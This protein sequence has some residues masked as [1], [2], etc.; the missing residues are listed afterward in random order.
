MALVETF[1]GKLQRTDCQKLLLL[2]CHYTGQ[3]YYDF[4]PYKY[5]GF[6]FLVYR[7]KER[8]E[9][10]GFL[11]GGED[12]QIKNGSSFINAIKPEDKL[13]MNLLS[14]KYGK[15]RGNPLIRQTYMEFPQYT[16]NSEI[17]AQVLS[18]SEAE[19]TRQ[20]WSRETAPCLFTIGYEGLT[21]DAYLN[22]LIVNNIKVVVDVR[23]IPN[24]MKYGFSKSK[25][26]SYINKA[27]MDYIHV[28]ELGVPTNMR[29]NLDS[30]DAYDAL[31]SYYENEI[32]PKQIIALEIII[33]E[34]EKHKRVALTCLEANH[35][36]CHRHKIVEYLSENPEFS[37]GVKHL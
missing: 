37:V 21:I 8:L 22:K 23:R 4:F 9:Q 6:S 25:L 27:G 13:A 36:M 30:V 11:T 16:C 5:G 20:G 12:F 29:Q 19:N 15:L 35:R 18:P 17:I 28:P 24:S 1:G 31:F 7:D 26:Q 3:N 34:I 10:M 33:N 2:F 32:L 14:T